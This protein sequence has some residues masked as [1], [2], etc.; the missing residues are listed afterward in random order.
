MQRLSLYLFHIRIV[1]IISD[2]GIAQVFHMNPY[3]MGTAG[4]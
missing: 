2:Q 4:L 1:Q 3:L